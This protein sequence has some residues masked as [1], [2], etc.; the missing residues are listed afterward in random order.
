MDEAEKYQQRLQAIAEKR[1]AQEEEDRARREIEEEWLKLAQRKR[2]SLRDQWLMEPT[3][4]STEASGTQTAPWTPTQTAEESAEETQST[5]KEM[6]EEDEKTA[7][8]ND[9]QPAR[10][11]ETVPSGLSKKNKGDPTQANS[12]EQEKADGATSKT[13]LASNPGVLLQKGPLERSVLGVLE[14]QVERDPKTGATTIKSMAPLSSAALDAT[15]QAVFDDGRRTVHAVGELEGSQHSEAELSQILNAISDVGMQTILDGVAITCNKEQEEQKEKKAQTGEP[16][17][18][19]SSEDAGEPTDLIHDPLQQEKQQHCSSAVSKLEEEEGGLNER[20]D[21]VAE[22]ERDKGKVREREVGVEEDEWEGV[23]CRPEEGLDPVVL[24]FLGF[25]QVQTGS[26]LG[27]E[28]EGGLLKVEQ[29][30]IASDEDSKVDPS[31]ELSPITA[32]KMPEHEESTK[33]EE[34]QSE[35]GVSL[36]SFS[37]RTQE[38][39]PPEVTLQMVCLDVELGAGVSVPL[40]ELNNV[41]DIM[42]S[43]EAAEDS[44]TEVQHNLPQ[45]PTETTN[46]AGDAKEVLEDSTEAVTE[47]TEEQGICTSRTGVEAQRVVK[48]EGKHESD[49]E[50]DVFQDVLLDGNGETSQTLIESETVA[51]SIGQVPEIQTLVS[52]SVILNRAG[53]ETSTKNKTCQC[54]T[55]M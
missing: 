2:K 45:I 40:Q 17:F 4:S 36:P 13:V 52:P 34:S 12:G 10:F 29:I 16:E 35:P 54:C 48:L 5:R 42:D 47:N 24:T 30:F 26:G 31:E 11:M 50:D 3:P 22:E 18:E 1:R 32:E 39:T 49:L 41:S 38:E 55:V 14:I 28:D 15:G 6:K 9:E 8:M 19:Q 37:E 51:Q 25:T 43:E 53:G 27:Y 33:C 23:N 21:V 20:R 7:N 44:V 46:V